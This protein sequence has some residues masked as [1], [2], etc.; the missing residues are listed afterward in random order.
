M[1]DTLGVHLANRLFASRREISVRETERSQLVRTLL[2]NLRAENV[3]GLFW[4]RDL[5]RPR[6]I[7]LL[8]GL[9]VGDGDQAVQVEVLNMLGR[10]RPGFPQRTPDSSSQTFSRVL[11]RP[12]P[13]PSCHSSRSGTIG[14][15]G[16]S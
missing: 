8:R 14:T 7:E 13:K 10:L 4:L 11:T 3:P 9:A 5:P 12:D 16:I 6:A 2:H 1:T 15:F